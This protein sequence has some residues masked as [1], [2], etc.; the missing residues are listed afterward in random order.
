[1]SSNFIQ[2]GTELLL[3]QWRDLEKV[4]HSINDNFAKACELLLKC[5]GHIIVTGLGKS[6]HIARKLAATL[7]S[8]GSPAFFLHPT[9]A[10]HGDMGMITA[11]DM[12][13]TISFSG[14]TPELVALLPAF[15][16]LNLPMVA[17]TGKALSPLAQSATA[18]LMLPKMEEACHLNLA[19]TT[20]STATLLLGDTLA[21]TVSKL[22]NF[23]QNDFALRHPGGQ[24]GQKLNLRISDIMHQGNM[25]PKV[26]A[27]TSLRDALIEITQK[28]LG[29][30]TVIDSQGHLEGIFTDGDLRRALD[31]HQLDIKKTPIGELMT[32]GCKSVPPA[33]LASDALIMMEQHKITAL[34]VTHPDKT[35]AGVVHLHDLLARGLD[36]PTKS[37]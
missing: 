23:S 21:M 26:T 14:N 35:L 4:K 36:V 3:A 5:E 12:L 1:M 15:R 24:L 25:I 17:I 22:R 30:T 27:R 2:M 11:K 6:G 7:A 32:L 16:R 31:H 9:E 19:P 33:M 28:K 8:T 37:S 10:A 13:L 20:S 34:T 29:F 18:T